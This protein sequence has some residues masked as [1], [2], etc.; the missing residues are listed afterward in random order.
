ME[1]GRKTGIMKKDALGAIADLLGIEA[2]TDE[3]VVYHYAHPTDDC[4]CP[5]HIAVSLDPK[6]SK[7]FGIPQKAVTWN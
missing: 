4:L 2:E 1:K 7:F 6:G 5:G 3:V